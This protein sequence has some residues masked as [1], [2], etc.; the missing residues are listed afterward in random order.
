MGQFNDTGGED[1]EE[2]PVV[3]DEEERDEDDNEDKDDEIG[4]DLHSSSYSFGTVYDDSGTVGKRFESVSGR[5]ELVEE[6]RRRGG[7]VEVERTQST[8]TCP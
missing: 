1:I 5:G 7:G 8:A 6:E 4:V 3:E 2:K